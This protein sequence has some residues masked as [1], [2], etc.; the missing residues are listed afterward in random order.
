MYGSIIVI[1]C[2]GGFVNCHQE[3]SRSKGGHVIS[4]NHLLTSE[5][6]VIGAIV[7]FSFIDH[8]FHPFLGGYLHPTISSLLR[9]MKKK[10]SI[11]SWPSPSS[12]TFFFL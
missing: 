1:D 10:P 12:S 4:H 8:I 2:I 3:M 5:I 6:R 7:D 9:I 11:P